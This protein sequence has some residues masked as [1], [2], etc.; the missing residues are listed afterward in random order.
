MKWIPWLLVVMLLQSCG[1]SGW[2]NE[3]N[4]SANRS[5]LYD[6]PT[7]TL[8]KDQLYQFEEG[9]F[10]GNLQKFHSDYSYR[11]AIIIGSK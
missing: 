8:R 5:A 7:V 11:R 9:Q 10:L 6:P 4:A 3:S 1:L 2:V